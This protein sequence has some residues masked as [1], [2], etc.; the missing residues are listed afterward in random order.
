MK[1]WSRQAA[2]ETGAKILT[3]R[4]VDDPLKEKSRYC[5]REFATVK[6]PT[7]F[8]AASDVDAT[9]ICGEEGLPHVLL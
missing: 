2:I 5:A 9:S 6:D 7:V 8:A 1:D 3:G 4:F